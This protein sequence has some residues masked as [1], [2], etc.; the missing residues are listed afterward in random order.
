[1]KYSSVIGLLTLMTSPAFAAEEVISLTQFN[2]FELEKSTLAQVMAKLGPTTVYKHG[3]GGEA[4]T[5]V[6]YYYPAQNVTVFYESGEMGN[7]QTLLSYQFHQGKI[8]HFSC[9]QI[10]DQGQTRFSVKGIN[11][12]QSIG[13]ATSVLP[14]K[15]RKKINANTYQ[16]WIK[17]PFTQAQIARME[18][19]PKFKPQWDDLITVQFYSRH[20]KVTGMRITRT[21]TW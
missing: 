19:R 14:S 1:M 17:R 4:S 5:G 16:Y 6:C 12:G 3:Q 13:Q 7:Q 9:G 20:A 21:I 2:G 15:L 10:E 18:V 8:G 11:L